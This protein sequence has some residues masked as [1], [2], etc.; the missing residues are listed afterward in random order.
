MN[1]HQNAGVKLAILGPMA[2]LVGV[3]EGNT[4][5][6]TSPGMPDQNET[7]VEHG[8]QERWELEHV[9]AGAQNHHQKL[10]VLTFATSAHRASPSTAG[11]ISGE[12][13]HAQCGFM[14]WDAADKQ[15]LA[16]FAVPRGIVIN[17]GGTVE[18]DATS[19]ELVAEAGSETY[20]ICQN[21]SLLENFK[22][23]RYILKVKFNDDGSI[24]YEQDTQLQIKGRGLM[25]HTDSN[26]LV[27]Q[28]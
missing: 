2:G 17:A 3:W 13:F 22:V 25:H 1:D 20:G 19:F 21:P 11:H 10:Q 5:T 14:V 9:P 12:A 28:S 26:H 16:S 18:P 27:R 7:D 24:D 4:G 6:D 15:L 8:Y 23:V